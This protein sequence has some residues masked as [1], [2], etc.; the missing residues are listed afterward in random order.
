MGYP[1]SKFESLYRNPATEVKRFLELKHPDAYKL[2]SLTAE[3][4]RKYDYTMFHNRVDGTCCLKNKQSLAG[5][6]FLCFLFFA[7]PCVFFCVFTYT[8]FSLL[9]NPLLCI[10]TT[11]LLDK[12]QFWDHEAPPFDMLVPFCQSVDQWLQ[13]DPKNVAVIHCKAGKGR[14]G[15]MICCY[16][17][18]CK[19]YATA[20]KAL[21][22][23]AEQRTLNQKGVTIPSQQRAVRY[24][25]ALL[26]QTPQGSFLTPFPGQKL[27]LR[28]VTITPVPIGGC[29][30]GCTIYDPSFKQIHSNIVNVSC[31]NFLWGC[32]LFDFFAYNCM[33]FFFVFF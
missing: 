1:A 9:L 28:K 23:Y 24:L 13:K 32:F 21:Q 12:Y 16:L 10:F 19:Q 11:Q 15:V 27:K 26:N 3:P 18:W 8:F 33:R 22:F 20:D 30:L 2:W 31:C 4:D 14:T 17:I 25:E 6:I 5:N 7:I 29:A